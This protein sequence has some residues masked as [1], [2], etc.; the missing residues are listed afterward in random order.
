MPHE[1][2]DTCTPHAPV[3]MSLRL[4]EV[5]DTCRPMHLWIHEYMHAHAPVAKCLCAFPFCGP[6]PSPFDSSLPIVLV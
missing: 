3:A 1:E 6:C 2:E 4:Y 5:E